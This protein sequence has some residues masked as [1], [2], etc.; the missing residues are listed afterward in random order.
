MGNVRDAYK[1][2]ILERPDPRVRQ[3]NAWTLEQWFS[4]FVRP[5]PGKFLFY[6]TRARYRAATRRLRNTALENVAWQCELNTFGSG[7]ISVA[8]C[9]AHV[10]ELRV[11]YK[12]R[13]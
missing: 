13:D 9:F 1:I 2:F 8:G 10:K 6:K 5:L 7:Q 11:P 3:T 12:L 4:Y